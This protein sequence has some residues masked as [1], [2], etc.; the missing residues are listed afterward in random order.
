V[1][2]LY[3]NGLVLP[4]CLLKNTTKAAICMNRGD[5]A[6]ATLIPLHRR[7]QHEE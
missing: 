7:H 2:T 3:H 4:N 5:E 6:P 1:P